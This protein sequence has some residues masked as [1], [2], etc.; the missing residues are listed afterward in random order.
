MLPSDKTAG[1]EGFGESPTALGEGGGALPEGSATRGHCFPSNLPRLKG[2]SVKEKKKK[3][4][5]LDP[6]E[7]EKAMSKKTRSSL[8][9]SNSQPQGKRTYR[10]SN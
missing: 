6:R 5:A 4:G 2:A 8:Q 10:V 7:K 9:K 1:Q 3:K